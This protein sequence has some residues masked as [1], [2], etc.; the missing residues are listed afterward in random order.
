MAAP[1]S[2]EAREL[3]LVDKVELRIAL[4]S[5]DGKLQS[6]LNTYLVPLLLKLSSENGDVRKKV[7][8]VCQHINT[9]IKPEN[10]QLPVA[11]LI[12]QFNEHIQSQLIRHFDLLYIQHGFSRLSVL[13]RAELLP[14]LTSGIH[15]LSIASSSQASAVFNLF[16]QS[17]GVY[18]FP[19][20]GSREDE[21][22]RAALNLGDDDAEYLSAWM[23]RLMLY[24][25]ARSNV[26]YAGLSRE[27]YDFLS[28]HGR[29]GV[30]NASSL[31]NAKFACVRLIAS[32]ALKDTERLMP[33]LLAS[34]DS[35]TRVAEMAEDVLKRCIPEIDINDESLI[36]Q[37][38]ALYLKRDPTDSTVLASSA[39]MRMKILRILSTAT[40]SASFVTEIRALVAQDLVGSSAQHGR[41]I[42]KLRSLVVQFLRTVACQ[43]THSDL[44]LINEDVLT[45]LK[46]FLDQ[47]YNDR[48]SSDLADLRGRGFEVFGLLSNGNGD[49]LLEP[50]LITLR[51][52]FRCLSEETNKQVAISITEALSSLIRPFQSEKR[53]EILNPLRD[54]LADGIS[55]DSVNPQATLHAILRF[56]NRCLP[57][58]DPVARWVNIA[59]LGSEQETSFEAREEAQKGLNPYWMKLNRNGSSEVELPTFQEMASFLFLHRKSALG[60][61]NVASAAINFSRQCLF[62]WCLA[63]EGQKFEFTSDWEA[64]LDVALRQDLTIRRKVCNALRKQQQTGTWDSILNIFNL[65][66]QGI[67]SETNSR[68]SCANFVLEL[69]SVSPDGLTHRMASAFVALESTLLANDFDTRLKATQIFGLL[70]SHPSN[71]DAALEASVSRLLK[72]ASLRQSAIGAEINK[73]HGAL[74]S[75]GHFAGRRHCRVGNSALVINTAK[76]ILTHSLTIINAGTDTL[77]LDAAFRTLSQ[78]CAFGVIGI[79][80]I[81]QTLKTEALI[82]RLFKVAKEGNEVAIVTLGHLGMNLDET[83]T[84]DALLVLSERLR[85]LHVIRQPETQFAVGESLANISCAW[86]SSAM[87]SQLLIDGPAPRSVFRTQTLHNV[88][89]KTLDAC[90]STTPALKRACVIWLLCLIQYCGQQ[91]EIQMQLR[92]FQVMFR[93]FLS[94]RD[95]LVQESASRGLGLVYEKGSS[96]IRDELVRDMISSFSGNRANLSGTMNEDTQLFEP[97]SLPTGDGSVSTYKDIMSL[98]SEVG[99]PS[100]VYRFM[101]LAA[102]NAIWSSRAAFGRFGLSN[103]LSDPTVDS[104]LASNPKMYAALY[105]YRFDPNS[106]VRQSMNGIWNALVR[107]PAATIDSYFELIAE[108]LITHLTGREWRARQASCAA[109]GD[110]LQGRQLAQIRPYLDR[111]WSQCFKVLDDIKETVRAAATGLARVL[112]NILVTNLDSD[113]GNDEVVPGL[114][115]SVIPFI[116]S[117]SGVESS[118]EEVKLL[119]I[120]T[121]LEIIKKAKPAVLRPF[122]PALVNQLLLLLT[123]FE[124]EAVNYVA[125]NA[126]NYNL[127]QSDIDNARLQSIR[128][129][130]IM[131]AIER[132]L[133]V[134]DETTMAET[135][136]KLLET[137]RV[138]VGVPSKVGCSRV[139]VSLSTRRRYLFQPLADQVLHAVEKRIQD[140]NETV[141]SSYA[142]AVGYLARVASDA[143]ILQSI[144]FAR[145]L[146][147]ENADD[148]RSRFVAAEMVQAVAKTATD[149]FNTLASDLVPL[150][151]FGQFDE[152]ERVKRIFK[153]TFDEV[154][155]GPRMV[156][157][158]LREIVS[159]SRGYLGSPK[160]LL[161]HAS[162]R[163][164][165]QATQSLGA[166]HGSI[167]RAEAELLWPPLQEALGQKSWDGKAEILKGFV[168]LVERGE[169]TW[170][171]QSAVSKE[172]KIVSLPVNVWVLRKAVT[173]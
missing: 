173:C 115:Q 119:S 140:R 66:C 171:S 160:W 14:I 57:F 54:M 73:V 47:R 6:L 34:A 45:T 77:L 137:M 32:G 148:D 52:L 4:A 13:E 31:A 59:T 125:L 109:L 120:R 75:L 72:Y 102:N 70:A 40:R 87:Q 89:S 9:R 11:A 90:T 58:S 64:K 117:T 69:V 95:E 53:F 84:G 93:R 36:K 129:S 49:S 105:R 118:A 1:L 98:A 41:E 99:D 133:D 145:Q 96:E 143:Q 162:A 111:A 167:A 56:A 81:E 110:L 26:S 163:A 94:D 131:E 19:P 126:S 50:E 103:V 22:L 130:P 152:V 63:D 28:V 27:E 136:R 127:T 15:R 85:A 106:N 39:A 83:A 128:S 8:S 3:A 121:L 153:E 149:R 151:F 10:V 7:I 21:T 101:T 132:A 113:A 147:F 104:H 65:S 5:D 165:S 172:I 161:K 135:V 141:S 123:S 154:A 76:Q 124:P 112:T 25:S 107:Q 62:W 18:S 144:A 134:L 170:R 43:A 23:A 35:N 88:V 38:F 16:L 12:K 114:L 146:Y 71:T 78:L 159:L 156:S 168:V 122:V 30:W 17:L 20:K 138:A 164:L 108:D 166:T 100:L 74:L 33:A 29:E 51:W 139:V 61:S 158:Y 116:L 82:E 142:G 80:D 169:G 60:D 155:S 46:E 44:A 2:S 86:K 67:V 24:K 37:L 97:G 42:Y 157:L 92:T 68:N 91:D 55:M 150:V 79:S 48:T